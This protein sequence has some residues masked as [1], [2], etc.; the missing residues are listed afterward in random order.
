MPV[1]PL[2]VKQTLSCSG[3]RAP[4]FDRG[5]IADH[6]LHDVRRPV[7]VEVF[8]F[9]E[10]IAGVNPHIQDHLLDGRPFEDAHEQ[11]GE[12]AT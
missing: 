5:N 4:L 2:M 11:P 7:D 8:K 1:L 6:A 12:C 3:C 9:S 10:K